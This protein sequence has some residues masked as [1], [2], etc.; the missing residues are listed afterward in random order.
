MRT[1]SSVRSD[2]SFFSAA[3]SDFVFATGRSSFSLPE[4]LWG[5]VP[6]LVAPYVIRRAGYRLCHR[7][8]LSTLPIDADTAAAAGLVD[9]VE[10]LPARSLQALLNRLR[11]IQPGSTGTAK[12]YLNSLQPI[13]DR[14]R[15]HAVDTLE[16]LLG[17]PAMVERLRQ[18]AD[19]QQL[20]WQLGRADG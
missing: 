11:R 6:C 19:H 3:A 8:T 7:L 15:D 20:P 4:A 16:G 18:F 1:G 2:G 5:L 14:I 10:E 9:T 13:D 17:T 12:R